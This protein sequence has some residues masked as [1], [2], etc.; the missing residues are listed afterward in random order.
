VTD[1]SLVT[2]IADPFVV[3][4]AGRYHCFFEVKS[5]DRRSLLGVRE[6]NPQFD[7][8]H[9][10]STDGLDWEYQG[11]VLSRTRAEHTYPFVFQH[12]EEWVMTPSPAGSTPDEFR[13]YRADRF[14]DE[15]AL[16]DRA[17]TGEVRIDPTPFEFEGTW[18]L[19]YQEAGTY[20][21]VL[22]YADSLVDGDWVEHPESPLFSPGGNDI[23]Q[24]GRPFVHDGS[25]DVFFRKGTPGIVEQWR[26]HD[27][28]PATLKMSELPA[29]PVV[30]GT[31]GDGWN[32]RNMHHVDAAPAERS[33]DDFALV[34]GQDEQGDYRLGI[35]RREPTDTVRFSAGGGETSFSPHTTK[36]LQWLST[37][38]HVEVGGGRIRVPCSGYYRLRSTAEVAGF[39]GSSR[40][41]FL[42]DSDGGGWRVRRRFSVGTTPKSVGYETGPLFLSEDD[43][44]SLS[45]SH[46]AGGP[47]RITGAELRGWRCW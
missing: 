40:C 12:A 16:V 30:S 17:L 5:R 9:A 47:V 4:E 34:D 44:L 3:Y 7:I 32:G 38:T 1:V 14:P 33:A 24:G 41:S 13:V 28:S 19:L 39:G 20:D 18:Y 27:L 10:T 45:V 26:F 15:W 6:T 35:Y 37:S 11:V 21:V 31:G 23:A 36:R 42:L 8:G 43:R 46:D 22:R 25:V 2:F 29:S